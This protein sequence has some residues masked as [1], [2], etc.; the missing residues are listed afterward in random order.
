MP[1]EGEPQLTFEKAMEAEHCSLGGAKDEF[2]TTYK[3]RKTWPAQEWAITVRGEFRSSH[4][5]RNLQDIEE[6]KKTDTAVQADLR[7]EEVIAVVLYTGPM[8]RLTCKGT[9][10][11]CPPPSL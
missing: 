1:V 4:G 7:R 11:F 10:L 9:S 2:E 8:V 6:L 3:K 5:T